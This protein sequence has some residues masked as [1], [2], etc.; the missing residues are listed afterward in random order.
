MDKQARQAVQAVLE[1][2]SVLEQLVVLERLSVLEQLMVLERLEWLLG[3]QAVQTVLEGLLA[4]N[5]PK[6]SNRPLLAIQMCFKKS[7]PEECLAEL[8]ALQHRMEKNGDSTRKIL[9]RLLW[10]SLG[11]LW[12]IHVHIKLDNLLLPSDC[13]IDD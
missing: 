4:K 5:R 3:Q 9:L 1:Q 12:A 6:D 2:L 13:K 10:E 11:I 7:L 8:G